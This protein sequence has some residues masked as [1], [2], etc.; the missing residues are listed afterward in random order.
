[1]Q[2]GSSVEASHSY[3][4]GRVVTRRGLIQHVVGSSIMLLAAACSAPAPVP[5]PTQAPPA[6]EAAA[7]PA[8]SAPATSVPAPTQAPTAV[9]GSATAAPAASA[10]KPLPTF[11]ASQAVKP[12]LRSPLKGVDAGYLSYPRNPPASVT[13]PPGRG[14]VVNMLTFQ[15]T[16]PVAAL[17]QNAALQELNKRLGAEVHLQLAPIADYPARLQTLMAGDDLPDTIYFSAPTTT[18]GLAQFLKSKCADLTPYLSGDAVK[19]YPNLAAFPTDAWKVGVYGNSLYGVPIVYSTLYRVFWAH[20]EL[21]EQAGVGMPKDTDDF[22]RVL[23]QITNPQAGQWGIGVDPDTGLGVTTWLEG[24]W[25]GAPNNWRLDAGGKLLKDRET[26]EYKVAVAYT[27]DLYA[28]GYFHPND[29][30]GNNAQGKTDFAGRKVAFRWDG[31]ASSVQFWDQSAAADPPGKLRITPPFSAPAAKAAFPLGISS[32][33]FSALK[34]GSPDRIR[35]VLRILNFLAAPFGTKEHLLV[36]YGAPDV[37]YTLDPNGSPILNDRGKAEVTPSW[38][39]VVRATPVLFNP[40]SSDFAR[41]LQADQVPNIQAGVADPTLGLYSETLALKGATAEQPFLDGVTDVVLG[42]RPLT[43]FDQ[44]VKDWRDA[45]G[46]Q[47]R[48]EL[49]HSLAASA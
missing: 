20:Q 16:P 11:I 17:D 10:S 12:D 42:R 4:F 15:Y 46:D 21:L 6:T 40:K 41:V 5:A 26:D 34:Q 3:P 39:F 30:T 19:D 49:E 28:A 13:E 48:N 8:T 33:G 29:V 27:R 32:G 22:K 24:T 23:Q 18:P 36:N 47:I 2:T 9:V 37:D 1:M 35:E 45:G 25:F 44:L 7:A 31:A 14:G 38:T 43:D